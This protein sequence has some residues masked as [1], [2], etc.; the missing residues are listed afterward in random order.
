MLTTTLI[1]IIFSLG[2]VQVVRNRNKQ[3]KNSTFGHF[4]AF[5]LLVL[6]ALVLIGTGGT[7]WTLM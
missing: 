1:S 2:F 3:R 7:S 5:L 4:L 6:N